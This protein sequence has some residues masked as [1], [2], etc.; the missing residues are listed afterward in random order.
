MLNPRSRRVRVAGSLVSTA[1]DGTAFT[2]VLQSGEQVHCS[3]SN[4][5]ELLPLPPGPVVIGGTAHFAFPET[6]R[7]IVVDDV[8]AASENDLSLWSERPRPLFSASAEDPRGMLQD[9]SS[10]LSAVIGAWPGEES[11]EEVFALLEELS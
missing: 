1:A 7:T 3:L 8:Q 9:R 5:D 4:R 11:D 6:L 2:L 10:N